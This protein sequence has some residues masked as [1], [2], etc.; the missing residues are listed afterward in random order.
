[1]LRHIHQ[2]IRQSLSLFW[3]IKGGIRLATNSGADA[4]RVLPLAVLKNCVLLAAAGGTWFGLEYGY[5]SPDRP[6]RAQWEKL[7]SVKAAPQGAL[8]YQ[9]NFANEKPGEEGKGPGYWGSYNGATLSTVQFDS[10]GVTVNYK[11]AAWLGAVFRLVAFEPGKIYRVTMQ[12]SVE[13]EPAALLVRN[14]QLD[15]TRVQIPVGSAPFA[16]EFVAPPGKLDR[17]FVIFMPDGQSDPK[18]SLRI[19]SVKI[20]R[21]GE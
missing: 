16:A 18:G 2:S 7:E 5:F 10:G 15:L 4:Q 17:V 8:V 11:D 1:M 19:T 13:G 14:R 12:G 3:H 9:S 6:T 21:L 20:E